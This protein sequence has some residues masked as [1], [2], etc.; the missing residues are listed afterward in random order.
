M[1]KKDPIKWA[2]SGNLNCSPP[3]EATQGF[4]PPVPKAIR[5]IK[6][7]EVHP[8]YVWK[9]AYW[10]IMLIEVE[11]EVSFND[12]IFPVCIPDEEILDKDHLDKQG[13]T[14]VGFGPENKNSTTM[15]QISQRVRSNDFCDMKYNPER[16]NIRKRNKRL[17]L[18]ELPDGFKDT[19]IC[20]QNR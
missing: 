11:E 7:I 4:I 14:I 1:E 13:L 9:K 16:A 19:L 10:D 18:K 20:A 6:K 3:K 8:K 17:L 15:N 12:Y 2:C 5:K